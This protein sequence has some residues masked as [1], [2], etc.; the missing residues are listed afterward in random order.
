LHG[1]G[2]GDEAI[3]NEYEDISRVNQTHCLPGGERG[4]IYKISE[5][6]FPDIYLSHFFSSQ[7]HGG[8]EAA[9]TKNLKI[10][11]D[12]YPKL[13]HLFRRRTDNYATHTSRLYG[14]LICLINISERKKMRL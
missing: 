2:D 14:V 6:F 4:A 7:I 13:A 12:I 10:F 8:Q 3:Y 1:R 11:P 5:D 9:I